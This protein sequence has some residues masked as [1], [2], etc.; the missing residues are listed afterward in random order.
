MISVTFADFCAIF[1]TFVALL[2]PALARVPYPPPGRTPPTIVHAT[3]ATFSHLVE[4]LLETV[5]I[6]EYTSY[7]VM[8]TSAIAQAARRIGSISPDGSLK[9][10]GLLLA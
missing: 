8:A 6:V 1:T 4:L 10:T 7:T 3:T 5:R 2:T 9:V